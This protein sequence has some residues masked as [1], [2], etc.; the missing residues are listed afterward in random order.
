[1]RGMKLTML[2]RRLCLLAG[3]FAM[4]GGPPSLAQQSASAPNG[5]RP[6][7]ESWTAYGG[8]SAATRFSPAE[9][10]TPGNAARL[11]QAWEYHTG[12]LPEGKF[13]GK[14]FS[15]Q[16]TPLKVGNSLYVCTPTNRVIALHPGTGAEQWSY[17]PE[18]NPESIGYTAACRGVA[19]F[20]APEGTGECARRIIAPTHDSRLI[21]LDAATGQLCTGFGDGGVI[22]IREGLDPEHPAYTPITSPPVIIRGVIVSGH[23]VL[24]GQKRD[25]PSGTIRGWD[26]VTGDFRWAWDMGRG[27]SGPGSNGPPPEGEVYTRGTPNMWTVASGDEELGLVYLPMGNAAGDYFGGERRPFD[28]EYSTSVVALDAVDGTVRWHFQTVHH[29]VWDYDL[30][31]QPTLVDLTV[32]G[33]TVPALILASKQ[34]SIFVLDRRDGRP[35]LPVEERPVPHEGVQGEQLSPTQPISIGMP[36]LVGPELTEQDMW[37]AT[38][39]DQL[40]CRIQF[41]RANYQGIFTPPSVERPWI[42]YPGYNGGVDWGGVAVDLDRNLLLVNYNRMP[43]FNQ[44]IPREKAREMGLVPVEEPG[45]SSASGGPVPQAGLPFGANIQVWLNFLNVPCIAPPWGYIMA[46]DLGTQQPVWRKPLGTPRDQGPF[47]IPS[48]IKLTIGTPNNGGSAV[49][50]GGVTFIGAALDQYLRA[51]NTE[52]GELLWEGRLPAGP[53][54]GPATYMHE[55]RQYVVIAAG[56][57][58][59]MKTKIGDSVVAFALPR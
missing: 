27:S 45:G 8:T 52:T 32:N 7:A 15:F 3:C 33:Q 57:H 50:R 5:A 42:Q 56:G 24:D 44:L 55:G 48:M 21:A 43:M 29:D 6:E 4:L 23:Q 18:I 54:A 53:Q 40:W 13:A 31:S 1:M 28:D 2:P 35:I 51:F 26:A 59:P 17:D 22:D 39:I 9:Q 16:A 14:P 11:E 10:I 37:G 25:A 30:G 20:E 58:G 36:S 38:L 34:G 46:I 41:R 49:T 19:Y 47:G 12:D